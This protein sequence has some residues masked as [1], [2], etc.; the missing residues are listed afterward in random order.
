VTEEGA[1]VQRGGGEDDGGGGREAERGG[2]SVSQVHRREGGIINTGGWWSREATRWLGIQ[3]GKGQ[4]ELTLVAG[5]RR[6]EEHQGEGKGGGGGGGRE[7]GGKNSSWLYRLQLHPPKEN[8]NVN[9]VGGNQGGPADDAESNHSPLDEAHWGLQNLGRRRHRPAEFPL[10]GH[11]KHADS[12][13]KG[14]KNPEVDEA[15][16]FLCGLFLGPIGQDERQVEGLRCWGIRNRS[17]QV[18]FLK[19]SSARLKS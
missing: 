9:L 10:K 7:P 19:L 4:V 18:V 5:D 13:H 12:D 6:V 15:N 16:F 3:G 2:E 14:R 1:L 17:G 8:E 11:R